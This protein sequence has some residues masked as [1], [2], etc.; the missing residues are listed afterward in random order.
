M[1]LFFFSSRRRHTSCAL[2]T[3]VQ[4]CALP[5][6]SDNCRAGGARQRPISW[7]MEK[8]R[9]RLRRDDAQTGMTT[10]REPRRLSV[11]LSPE[12]VARLL[13]AAPGLNAK[14][15]LSASYGADRT[16]PRLNSRHNCAL[17]MPSSDWNKTHT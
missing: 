10:V 6:S 9:H 17:R 1:L 7:G 2:V 11:I 15:A 4:T 3:G 12:E 5:I 14:A 13:D 16:G 8:H